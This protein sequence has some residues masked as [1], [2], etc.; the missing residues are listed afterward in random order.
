MM[1]AWYFSRVRMRQTPQQFVADVWDE[2]DTNDGFSASAPEA[3]DFDVYGD[4]QLIWQLF[5]PWDDTPQPADLSRQRPFLYRKEIRSRAQ[6][7]GVEFYVLSSIAPRQE[8]PRL[9]V[10]TKVYQPL[11]HEGQQLAF[12]LRANPIVQV[13]EGEKSRKHDVMTH[14]FVQCKA[15]GITDKRAIN[16]A[17]REAV[18]QWLIRT[19]EME[20]SGMRL[21][22]QPSVDGW[23]QEKLHKANH[24]QPIS[25][26]QVDFQG[27]LTVTN[28]ELFLQRI[29]RGIGRSRSFGCGLMLIK[30]S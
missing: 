26:T 12:M 11:I 5:R 1:S 20:D 21:I 24:K 17:K 9:E 7:G 19:T 4:H 10:D 16:D 3:T 23:H 13:R 14:T 25:F 15:K 2:L 22:G 29:Y 6:G 28:P 18:I 27:M 8:H 30:R